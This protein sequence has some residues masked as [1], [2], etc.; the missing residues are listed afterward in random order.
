MRLLVLFLITV[1]LLAVSAARPNII[2]ILADDL[3]SYDVSWRGGEIKTPNLDKLARAG[4][5]LDQFY[6]QPVCTPTRAALL[7]GRYP[8]RYGLQEIGRA[9]C[10]ERG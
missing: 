5:Q 3:G 10:R 7:T 4:A 2:F 6:V 8:M 9:S 1:P